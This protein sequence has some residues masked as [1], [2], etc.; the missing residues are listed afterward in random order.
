MT[1]DVQ[2]LTGATP[3]EQPDR[4]AFALPAIVRT[5]D[6]R[7]I[8]Q[9]QTY[10][11]VTGILKV[12][13]KSDALMA[14]ASRNT[15]EAALELFRSGSLQSMLETVGPGGTVKAM[16][17]RSTW[18][19]DEAADLG[20]EVHRLADLYINGTK[21]PDGLPEAVGTRVDRYAQWWESSRWTLRLSE[22]L[23]VHPQMGYGGT[24]DLLARD[25]DGRTILADIK[26]GKAVYHEAVL[27]LA[28][29]G[30][31]ELVAPAGSPVAYAMPRPDRYVILHVTLEGVRE[32]EVPI[33]AAEQVAFSACCDLA[34]WRKTLKG[35]SL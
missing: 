18:K 8:Y 21:L 35:R 22:A 9:G 25:A 6:H 1:T 27:Q 31:A 32:V 33:G 20:S 4:S 7:Y 14:W 16:T 29:Y 3:I 24:F 19:R 12:L 26:T 17:S 13:D 28:A 11:G 5:Q 10:P 15:A 30:M 34:G 2:T 23:V